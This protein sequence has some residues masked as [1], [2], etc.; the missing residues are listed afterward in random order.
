[1]QDNARKML[2]G[3]MAMTF[4]HDFGLMDKQRREAILAIMDQ[5]L[6]EVERSYTLVPRT[7]YEVCHLLGGGK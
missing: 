4:R 2:L 6:S 1:M 7:V 5:L 3:Q